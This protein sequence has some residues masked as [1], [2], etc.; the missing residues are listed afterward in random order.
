MGQFWSTE[1]NEMVTI[2]SSVLCSEHFR[3]EDC[4]RSANLDDEQNLDI[5]KTWLRADDF[6]VCVF[7]SVHAKT[8]HSK[9]TL[10]EQ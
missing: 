7:P 3:R 5:A 4:V 2:T 9:K 1:A 10:M 8:S 6:G